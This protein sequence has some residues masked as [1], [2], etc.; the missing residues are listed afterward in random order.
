M[1]MN[2]MSFGMCEIVCDEAPGEDCPQLRTANNS[3]FPFDPKERPH[4]HKL[5]RFVLYC[6]GLAGPWETDAI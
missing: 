5:F 1:L 6:I 2:L 3:P 4:I